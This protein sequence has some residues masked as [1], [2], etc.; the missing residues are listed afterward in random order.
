MREKQEREEQELKQE[1]A[2]EE[3]HMKFI[4][5]AGMQREERYSNLRGSINKRVSERELHFKV[6]W[7][8]SLE[9]RE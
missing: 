5:D 9:L 8:G 1:R 7:E 3:V 2:K 4:K 6:G